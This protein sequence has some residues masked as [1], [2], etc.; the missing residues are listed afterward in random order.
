MAAARQSESIRRDLMLKIVFTNGVTSNPDS[1]ESFYTLLVR[2]GSVHTYVYIC[3]STSTGTVQ[4]VD[5]VRAGS[6]VHGAGR[7]RS[8]TEKCTKLTRLKRLAA[9]IRVLSGTT[10]TAYMGPKS[11]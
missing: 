2:L 9:D 4:H 7:V 6:A 8:E 1:G 10:C 3:T 11:T 5:K